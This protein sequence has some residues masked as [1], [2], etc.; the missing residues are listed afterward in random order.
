MAKVT[1]EMIA[2]RL[3]IS[4]TSVAAGLGL[5]RGKTVALTEETKQRIVE[6]A[7]EMGY[8]PNRFAQNVAGRNSKVIGVMSFGGISQ[9][10]T[11]RVKE[12]SQAIRAAGYEMLLHEVGWESREN[13]TLVAHSLIDYHVEALILIEPTDWFDFS[14]LAACRKSGIPVVSM[15]GVKEKGIPHIAA[16]EYTGLRELT[17]QLIARGAR[18]LTFLSPLYS[19]PE[20][21]NSNAYTRRGGGFVD[22]IRE[23]GGKILEPSTTKM[24]KG[25]VIGALTDALP[26]PDWSD[27]YLPGYV[28]MKKVLEG[29]RLPDAVVCANDDWAF[30]ALRC[31]REAGLR[32]PEDLWITGN[33]GLIISAYGE[34]PLTT[35]EQPMKEMAAA[36]VALVLQMLTGKKLSKKDFT[37]LIAP[38]VVWRRSTEALSGEMG[39]PASH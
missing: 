23:S 12:I 34:T 1:Q 16:D 26:S 36:T 22:A 35:I 28:G 24:P 29:S 33:D 37:Q 20:F 27:P 7:R 31:C 10:A 2:Q 39:R 8:R 9:A 6:T 4:R 21:A 18:Y 15:G 13:A 19:K 11:Q 38:C 5:Y 32:V 30:G 14:M 25:G 3:G 17:L